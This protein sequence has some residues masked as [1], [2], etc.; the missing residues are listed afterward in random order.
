MAIGLV[1]GM[2]QR[3]HT[4]RPVEN[5]LKDDDDEDEYDVSDGKVGR[6]KRITPKVLKVLVK[7]QSIFQ[8]P[9]LNDKLGRLLGEQPTAAVRDRWEHA[10]GQTLDPPEARAEELLDHVRDQ[11]RHKE[12]EPHDDDEALE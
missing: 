3:T 5:A 4:A 10:A 2:I 8:V 6:F 12:Q 9:E 1:D 11:V 7:E